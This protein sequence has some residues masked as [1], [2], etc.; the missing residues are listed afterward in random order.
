MNPDILDLISVVLSL[1]C[2]SFIVFEVIAI[3]V[4]AL[5]E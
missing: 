5:G 1:G 2:V 3:A 4:G